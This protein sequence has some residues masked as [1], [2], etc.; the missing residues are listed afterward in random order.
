MGVY[1]RMLETPVRELALRE[2][3]AVAGDM[4]VREAVTRMRVKGIGC[5]IVTDRSGKPRGMF[6]EAM[7]R[8]LLV[9]NMAALGRP[10]EE[11]MA[12]RFPWVEES[13]PVS[14]VLEAMQSKNYRFVC[15]VDDQGRATAITGQKGL[16][17]FLAKHGP[18][19]NSGCR[20]PSDPPAPDPLERAMENTPVSRIQTQP[21]TA[22]PPDMPTSEA[23]GTLA[24][25]EIS[26]LMVSE[27]G[28]LIGVFGD[29]DALDHVTLEYERVIHQPVRNVMTGEPLSI[30]ANE[31][32]A[33]AV[34]V[35]AES[36]YRHLPVLDVDDTLVG[37]ISPQRLIT[38]LQTYFD[39]AH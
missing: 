37:I 15:V 2:A 16:I 26:C 18:A 10:I 30:R 24:R 19:S 11:F 17:E 29:R 35:M 39:E 23:L 33:A 38:F 5:A 14:M 3:L 20:Q 25:T 21:F 12:D 6:T 7:L 28:R 9:H 4:T 13:D 8:H 32:V 1:Q 31:S 36:G 34:Q 22:V 27:S